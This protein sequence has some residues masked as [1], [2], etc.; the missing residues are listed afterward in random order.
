VLRNTRIL[1][2]V[3]FAIRDIAAR[4]GVTQG[5]LIRTFIDTGLTFYR[6]SHNGS[7]KTKY[8][9]SPST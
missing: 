7:G 8:A 5:E 3:D 4:E 6:Q 2:G 1:P 9:A